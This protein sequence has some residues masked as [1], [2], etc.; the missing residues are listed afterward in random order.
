M[1]PHAPEAN[2]GNGRADRAAGDRTALDPYVDLGG[3][4]LFVE[5]W[6][7]GPPLVCVHG[8]GGAAHFFSALGPALAPARR[9]I[10]FDLPGSGRSP[11]DGPFSFDAVADLVIELAAHLR[12]TDIVL[13]GHSLG[14]IVGLEVVRRA[15]GLVRAF[16]SVGGLPAPTTASRDR[17]AQRAEAVARHGLAGIANAV[18]EANFSRRT[19]EERPELTALFGRLFET[20]SPRAYAATARALAEWAARPLPPFGVTKCMAV[21]FGLGVLGGAAPAVAQET[22]VVW[23][24]KGFYKSEDDALYAELLSRGVSVSGPPIDQTWGTREIGVRDADRN[25]VTFGQ[26]IQL[27]K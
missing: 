10:A 17:I 23:W 7:S 16:A 19:R 4:R 12:V 24:T 15:P 1:S 6:G 3:Q 18:V 13:V 11:L 5:Q 22:L 14:A 21:M 9:T 26:R 2:V 25:V 20:Q 27:T 8:L